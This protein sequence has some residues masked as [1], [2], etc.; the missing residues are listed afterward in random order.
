MSL[1]VGH[2]SRDF[3]PKSFSDFDILIPFPDDVLVL[4][5]G[6]LVFLEPDGFVIGKGRLVDDGWDLIDYLEL[7]GLVYAKHASS[8]KY[9]RPY[10]LNMM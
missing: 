2:I 10:Y 1:E 3:K 4:E 7:V 9:R 5:G 8:N 6:V